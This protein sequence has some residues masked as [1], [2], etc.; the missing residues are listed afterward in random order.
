[1]YHGPMGRSSLSLFQTWQHVGPSH[2]F[3]GTTNGRSSLSFIKDL[4][5]RAQRGRQR[6]EYIRVQAKHIQGPSPSD[7][8]FKDESAKIQPEYFQCTLLKTNRRIRHA[9]NTNNQ[10]KKMPGLTVGH[11]NGQSIQHIERRVQNQMMFI[12][13]CSY[14]H[15]PLSNHWHRVS[16][17]KR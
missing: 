11:H 17:S 13:L 1:M 6:D 8:N 4:H 15:N 2:G 12:C 5:L 7:K 16:L 10:L 9:K 14:S 3:D